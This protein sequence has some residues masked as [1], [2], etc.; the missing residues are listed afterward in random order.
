[1]HLSKIIKTAMMFN[2]Y[3]ATTFHILYTR[4]TKIVEITPLPTDQMIQAMKNW[5]TYQE[6]YTE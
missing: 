3:K 2:E 5:H 1:M 6:N 4:S